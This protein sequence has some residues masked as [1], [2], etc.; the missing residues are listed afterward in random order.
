MKVA[1]LTDGIYP[2]VLGGMQKHSYYL[3]KYLAKNKIYVDLY[4][5]LNKENHTTNPLNIFTKSEQKYIRSF[6]IDFPSYIRFPGHYLLESYIYSKKIF[7]V[8][9]QQDKVDFIYAKGFTGWRFISCKKREL[10]LSPIGINFHGYEM[11]Q[12]APSFKAKI[13]QYL[14]RKSVIFNIKQADYA[15]SYGGN[16]TGIIQNLG[17]TKDRIISIPTGIESIFIHNEVKHPDKTRKFVFIG[18][19]ERRKGIEEINN[20]LKELLAKNDINFEFHFVGPIPQKKKIIAANIKYWGL[21]TNQ[22]KLI[23]I[24]KNLD[25]LVCPSYSEGMPNV[26]LEAMASGLAVIAT[27]VGAIKEIVSGKNGWLIKP[28]KKEKLK[29]AML[30]ALTI[31][32]EA[33]LTKKTN[34]NKLVKD[35]LSWDII[36]QKTINLISDKI[37]IKS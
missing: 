33:L 29:N 25:V 36:I 17:I 32:N 3:V 10:P 1:L 4:H 14:L 18:R 23:N 24:I 11:F 13:E 30:N 20:V 22:K 2:Y 9:Q 27:D 28:G 35:N 8:F 31:S 15:F 37:I 5:T 26:I 21:I 7:K 34:A 19:Y 6:T 16:I 12:K